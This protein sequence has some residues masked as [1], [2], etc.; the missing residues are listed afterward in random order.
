MPREA[1]KWLPIPVIL[2]WAE[3]DQEQALAQIT[4][5]GVNGGPILGQLGGVKAGQWWLHD[6]MKRA[7]I[8]ALS[9]SSALSDQGVRISPVSGS[10][11]SV[12]WFCFAV[13]AERRR[14]VDCL[15]R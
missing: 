3:H 15:R 10:T 2:G 1:E 11:S 14:P 9:I 4:R 5:E 8:G 12:A 6:D 13:A 7:P